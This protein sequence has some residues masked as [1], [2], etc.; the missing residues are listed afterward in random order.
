M[1]GGW[2]E[3]SNEL[4]SATEKA[5]AQIVAVHT[6]PRGSSSGIVLRSGVIVTAEHAL[7]SDEEIRVTLPDGREAGAALAGRDGASDVAV[8]NCPEA[9]GITSELATV[10]GLRPASV[11][12]LVG[13]TRA[14]GPV[15][16]LGV[17][18]LYVKE[19]SCWGGTNLKPYIRL[20]VGLQ[21]TAVGGAVVD[22]EGRILGMATPRFA[23]YGL[24]VLPA[25]MLNPIVDALLKSGRVPRGYLGVGLQAVRLPEPL[26]QGLSLSQKSGAIVLELEAGGPASKAG[27]LIG[28][29]LVGINGNPVQHLAEV[30][31]HLATSEAGGELKVKLIRGGELREFTIE[32]G[33]RP[34]GGG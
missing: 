22:A 13:R 26:R 25:S 6:G 7:R 32:V 4:A 10:E 11:V 12:L 20:D 5:S 17:V 2:K 21:R 30:H 27:V 3:L 23:G 19:R 29:I 15:A 16:A 18:S 14:S 28:D 24:L 1:S 9:T 33:K 8:L 34:H 31:S